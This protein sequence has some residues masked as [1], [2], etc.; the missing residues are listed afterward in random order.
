MNRSALFLTIALCAAPAVLVAQSPSFSSS[1]VAADPVP[2]GGA[3]Q[4]RS[5]Y[6][7]SSGTSPTPLSRIG[8]GVGISPL[9][10]Q[11]EA[12][13]NLSNHF[14]LRGTGNFFNYSDNF[15]T[16]GINATAKLNLASARASVDVYPFR[17]G[18]RISPGLMFINHNQVTA[19]TNVAAG[20][21]FTLNGTTYYSANAN[22]AT[23]AT[24]SRATESWA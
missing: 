8:F 11:L 7:T 9:G 21:G 15:T 1:L 5:P 23:G 16:D 10:I 14:N 24:P 19:A 17:R 2:D 4:A 6:L 12:A 3:A 13:T 20:T 18:W 22:A